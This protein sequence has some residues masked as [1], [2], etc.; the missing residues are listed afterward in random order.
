MKSSNFSVFLFFVTVQENSG[1]EIT[2]EEVIHA[3][4]ITKDGKAAGPDE[5]PSEILKLIEEE[6]IHSLTD[7]FNTIYR[8][9]IIPRE[10]LLSAFVTIPKKHNARQCTDFRTI[11]LMSH[12]LKILLKVIHHR[13]YKTLEQDI[14]ETQFG[15]RDGLGTREALFALNVLA[16][17]C[18]D[19]NQD[20]YICFIDYNKAFDRVRHEQLIQLLKE[21]NLDTR[22]IKIITNLYFNQKAVVKIEGNNT[23]EIEIRRG[24][25]QGCVL[26]PMLFNLY[27]EE[28]MKRALDDETKGLK[29]NGVPINNIRYADDTILMAANLNDLQIL[30]DKVNTSSEELGLSLNVKKTKFMIISKTTQNNSQ[31]HINNHTIEKVDSYKYLGTIVNKNNDCS[32]EIKT[33]IGQ[34]RTTFVKMKRVLCGSDLSLDLKIRMVRCYVLSVLY[35]GVEAWTLKKLDIRKLEAFEIWLYRRILRVKWTDKVTN[36]EILKRI[37]KE[38]EII[39]TV[40]KRKLQYLGHVMRG[41]KYHLL[42]LILQGKIQGKRSV[43]RRRHSWMRNLRDWFGCTTNQ[44]FRSAVSRIRIALMIA[45]LRNEEGI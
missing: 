36:M 19:M 10:W 35:Y 2:K 8:T 11:S 21:K 20:L 34:A 31:I 24:V 7:L 45:N 26:S 27:S 32:E 16:Q 23:E 15:F 41:E 42:Q 38:K 40:K 13:I 18:M 30:V 22:D 12:T 1:P 14:S 33:R 5:L 9:G 37:K 3:I 44:L 4:K 6:N 29:I 17:R 39:I 28:I 25:R 43:G